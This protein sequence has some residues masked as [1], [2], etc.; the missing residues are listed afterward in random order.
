MAKKRNSNGGKKKIKS[1]KAEVEERVTL[2]ALEAMSDSDVEEIPESQWNDKAKSLR[3]A[4]ED[5]KFDQLINKLKESNDDGDDDEMEEATIDS[6]G[7][8]A[9]A[10]DEEAEE[11]EVDQEEASESGNEEN[12]EEVEDKDGEDSVEAEDDE[13]AEQNDEENSDDDDEDE[14]EEEEDEEEEKSKRLIANNHIAS[15]ALAVVTAELMA[16]HAGLPWAETFDIVPPT[17]L[18]FTDNGDPENNPLDIHDDL[19]REVAFYN[20]ALEAV[21]EARD[22]CKT[23]NVPFT[24]PDDFF[25]EMVKTD[26]KKTRLF[27][28]YLLLYPSVTENLHVLFRS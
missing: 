10:A 9:D 4:I 15:K 8:E 17:P 26:G 23:A 5:G 18:P 6:N 28:F 16:A 21:H 27:F 1:P 25:A 13:E 3:Q 20:T 24:R 19:K 2:E 7:E 22:L 14:S 11:E 12:E